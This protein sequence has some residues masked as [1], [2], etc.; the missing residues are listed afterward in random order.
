MA[1]QE[2]CSLLLHHL[3]ANPITTNASEMVFIACK[4]GTAFRL[5][6]AKCTSS[7]THHIACIYTSVS[8]KCMVIPIL[9]KNWEES[10]TQGLVEHSVT[11]E[12]DLND[13]KESKQCTCLQIQKQHSL[14]R[15]LH[16]SNSRKLILWKQVRTRADSVQL[17]YGPMF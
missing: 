7:K 15:C 13:K 9:F 1:N 10:T 8:S 2:E 17:N 4:S 14:E 3:Q 6:L 11:G 5:Q 12:R 16:S